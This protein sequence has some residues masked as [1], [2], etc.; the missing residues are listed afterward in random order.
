MPLG[1]IRLSKISGRCRPLEPLGLG[2]KQPRLRPPESAAHPETR[3]EGILDAHPHIVNRQPRFFRSGAR[4]NYL[5]AG[6]LGPPAGKRNVRSPVPERQLTET[7]ILKISD[8]TSTGVET[9]G[10]EPAT[11]G[12]QSRRSPN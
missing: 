9:T 4:R 3:E 1:T 10:I 7:K 6:V 12:L 5:T 8:S 2:R 11:S